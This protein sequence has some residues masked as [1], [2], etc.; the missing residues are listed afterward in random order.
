M[1]SLIQQTSIDF[2]IAWCFSLSAKLLVS[3][4]E[5]NGEANY[6]LHCL[7]GE[8]DWNEDICKMVV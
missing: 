5:P 8:M 3:I 6:N 7:S 4:Y 1:T 2:W